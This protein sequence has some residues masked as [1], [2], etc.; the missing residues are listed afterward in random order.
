[1]L[2]ADASQVPWP[3][4]PRLVRLCR[5]GLLAC[6]LAPLAAD[7]AAAVPAPERSDDRML[8]EDTRL[9]EQELQLAARPQIYLI[10]DLAERAILIKGRGLELYRL[11]I[12]SWSGTGTDALT[13]TFR[14][15]ARPP[16]VRPRAAGSPDAELDP[17]ELADMP[18]AYELVFEPALTL[19]ISPPPQEGLWLWARGFLAHWWGRLSSSNPHLHLILPQEVGQSLAWTVTDGMA[20]LVRRPSPR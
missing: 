10:V 16:V 14:L 11:P 13:G 9:L 4:P 18:A 5:I 1:M 8:Q 2:V 17:I 19:T 6:A 7:A 15:R 3:L 20:A 12:Q